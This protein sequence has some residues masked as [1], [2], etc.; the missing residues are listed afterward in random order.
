LKP[1]I[2]IDVLKHEKKVALSF[3]ATLAS[4]AQLKDL[5]DKAGF[6]VAHP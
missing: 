4:E 2:Y 1:P 6:L 3:D 5:L